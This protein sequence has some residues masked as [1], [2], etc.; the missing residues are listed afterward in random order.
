[1]PSNGKGA[2]GRRRWTAACLLSIL[3]FLVYSNTYDAAWHLDDYQ[4]ITHNPRIRIENLSV[5]SLNQAVRSPSNPKK[6]N[7]PLARATLAL[8][9][10][11]GGYAPLGYHLV[12]IVVHILSA[13]FLFLTV[14]WLFRTPRLRGGD[15]ADFVALLSATLWAVHPIQ[16]QAVTYIVQ[17]M[18][19]MA[20]MFCIM[21]MYFYVRG[22]LE[23]SSILRKAMLFGACLLSFAAGLA[24]KEN[25]ALLPLSLL[26]VEAAFFQDL[27]RLRHRKWFPVLVIL[28]PVVVAAAGLALYR[29]GNPT[30]FLNGF[31]FRYF[32][33]LERLMTEPRVLIFYITQLVYPIP[34]RLSIEHD[35]VISTS[36]LH[37][38]TTLPSI[39]L[40]VFMI[41]FGCIQLQRRPF[42]GFAILFFFLNHAVESTVLPLELIFEH[43]NYLPSAFLFVPVAAGLENLLNAYRTQ[44]RRLYAIIAGFIP[45]LVIGMGMGAYIRNMT[46]QTPQSLWQDAMAKAPRSGRPL[47]NLAWAYYERIGDTDKAVELYKKSL[48]LYATNRSQ[49]SVILNNLAGIYY[50]RGQ[51]E[52]AAE[53]WKDAVSQFDRY[54]TGYYRA[55][56]SLYRTGDIPGA[57]ACLDAVLAKQPNYRDALNFKGMIMARQGRHRQALASFRQCHRL[58]PDRYEYILNIGAVFALMNDTRRA[59]LFFR[60]AHQRAPN[61]SLPLVWLADLHL[62]AGDGH[63]AE[64]Y[65][66]SLTA[67]RTPEQILSALREP[68]EN[69]MMAPPGASRLLRA[70][71]HKMQQAAA[72]FDEAAKGRPN[73]P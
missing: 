61:S 2:S 71:S 26:L 57:E 70:L 73:G 28:G 41:G 30:G 69:Q 32:S 46:W 21:A 48:P 43:R 60:L 52:R 37:P 5:S 54:Y 19:S 40:I 64:R 34:S 36:L 12:N 9:W 59:D 58:S 16:T 11:W 31:G 47:H 27:T 15:A 68:N 45:L 23:G 22:R 39:V 18:A 53:L 4:N 35:V 55:A 65:I 42:L 63:R 10:Y 17:R 56:L 72:A 20:A 49:R 67:S 7:R 3:I 44:N 50:G 1:M 8:N 51:Y 62:Q 25:A 66:R 6:I 24:S 33:P 29:G 38:W 13:I 14:R